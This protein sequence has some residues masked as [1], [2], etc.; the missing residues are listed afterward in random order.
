MKFKLAL[1]TTIISMPVLAATNIAYDELRAQ[2]MGDATPRTLIGKSVV[3]AATSF[4]ELGF[5]TAKGK[6]LTFICKSGDKALT[7][8][9]PKPITFTG[10][11]V[12]AQGWEGTTI[13]SLANCQ[14]GA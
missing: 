13:W 4:G 2:S 11:T 1:L 10:T 7:A 6:E 5:A 12:S 9:R 8:K 3:V 14:P